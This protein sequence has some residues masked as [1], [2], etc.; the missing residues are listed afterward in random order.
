MAEIARLSH[1]HEQLLNWLVLNP[2]R[3]LRE[4]ADVFGFSQS[5]LSQV[6]HS[7]LFQHALKEKQLA[8][9]VRVADSIPQKLRRAADLALEK[10]TGKLE[11][12]EDP[13]YILDATDKILHRMGYAPQSARNP[14]GGPGLGAPA[15]QNNFFISSGDLQEAR[16]L[17]QSVS[18]PVPAL[19][20]EGELVPQPPL[21]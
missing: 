21:E 11:D 7:D 9:G 5:W 10:L 19:T 2:D 17:M 4:C 1:K 12:T 15:Q 20:L 14:A 18:V 3:S 13:E 6:I 8:I 16:A